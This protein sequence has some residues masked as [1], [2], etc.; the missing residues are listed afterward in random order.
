MYGFISVENSPQMTTVPVVTEG[1][2]HTGRWGLP[3]PT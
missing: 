1:Y 2:T 3:L